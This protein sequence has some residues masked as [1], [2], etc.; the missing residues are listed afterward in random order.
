M[1][2]EKSV[3]DR[4]KCHM[5]AK[6]GVFVDENHNKIPTM[7]W[8]LKLHKKPINHVVLLIL[9]HIILLSCPYF[10]RLETMHLKL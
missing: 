7:Y 2:D 8:L 3:I 6:F 4:H 1:L 10:Q 5:A 9:G